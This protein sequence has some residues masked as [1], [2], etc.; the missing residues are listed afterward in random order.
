MSY[1]FM[2]HEKVAP[3]IALE[4]MLDLPP[5]LALVKEK[6]AQSAFRFLDSY[7]PNKGS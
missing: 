1:N 5:L 4:A 2:S 3:T 6:A 7:K